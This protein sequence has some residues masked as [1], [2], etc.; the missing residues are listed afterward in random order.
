[1]FYRQVQR[2]Q[3]GQADLVAHPTSSAGLIARAE[4]TVIS[5]IRVGLVA[6]LELPLL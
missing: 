6:L 2:E 5:I 4:N 1:M 3:L